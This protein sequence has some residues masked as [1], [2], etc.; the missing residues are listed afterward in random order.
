M[1]YIWGEKKAHRW[2]KLNHTASNI[3][4]RISLIH[5]KCHKYYKKEN[6]GGSGFSWII[7]RGLGDVEIA[8]RKKGFSSAS[9]LPLACQTK[10]LLQRQPVALILFSAAALFSCAAH[11]PTNDMSLRGCDP[12]RW[13]I[14]LGMLV[15]FFPESLV[16]RVNRQFEQR[17]LLA[18]SPGG[19]GATQPP[20]F[21]SGQAEAPEIHFV[22]FISQRPMLSLSLLSGDF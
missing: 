9:E 4:C 2:K 8:G 1:T 16:N 12:S 17:T 22:F 13:G 18:P 3:K 5:K 10:C 6:E 19:I 15:K 7:E 20:P 11:S 14:L 21:R